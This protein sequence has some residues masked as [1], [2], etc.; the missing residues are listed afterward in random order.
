MQGTINRNKQIE[1]ATFKILLFHCPTR[2]HF[3]SYTY[4]YSTVYTYEYVEEITNFNSLYVL[5]YDL[6]FLE[7]FELNKIKSESGSICTK[8]KFKPEASKLQA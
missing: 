8:A 1:V 7:L 4:S 2:Q 3:W 6:F 5:F